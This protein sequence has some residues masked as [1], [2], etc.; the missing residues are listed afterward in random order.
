[1]AFLSQATLLLQVDHHLEL[2]GLLNR[3]IGRLGAFE[4]SI[5]VKRCSLMHVQI[6]WPIGDQ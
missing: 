1:M 4:T 2:C 3:Q 6:V 5:N